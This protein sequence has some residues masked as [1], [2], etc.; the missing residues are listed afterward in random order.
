MNTRLKGHIATLAPEYIARAVQ[1]QEALR[2]YVDRIDH[3]DFYCLADVF[4]TTLRVAL[5]APVFGF[6]RVGAAARNINELIATFDASPSKWDVAR[7]ECLLIEFDDAVYKAKSPG[8]RLPVR[9]K[10][11]EP[12]GP[13]HHA[14]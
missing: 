6:K 10:R 11:K 7:L 3:E 2:R 1:Q 8:K 14:A 13:L 12:A 4:E 9:R 5:D